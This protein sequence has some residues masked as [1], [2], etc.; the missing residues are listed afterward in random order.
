MKKTY[1]SPMLTMFIVRNSTLLSGSSFDSHNATPEDASQ[2]ASR[3]GS[4][5]GDDE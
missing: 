1:I 2:A 4:F 3:G 5:W